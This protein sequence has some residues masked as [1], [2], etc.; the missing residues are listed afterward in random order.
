M[1]KEHAAQHADWTNIGVDTVDTLL[2][3]I[4]QGVG[5]GAHGSGDPCQQPCPELTLFAS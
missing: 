3:E 1:G 5:D 4:L 2:R